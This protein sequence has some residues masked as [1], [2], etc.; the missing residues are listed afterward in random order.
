MKWVLVGHTGEL[1]EQTPNNEYL[2]TPGQRLFLEVRLSDWADEPL[3]VWQGVLDAAL[4]GQTC[5]GGG[6][7]GAAC[8]SDI[9]CFDG[10]TCTANIPVPLL[11]AAEP[12]S[13][14][15]D[16]RDA[17]GNATA[18]CNGGSG[19]CY[20][21]WV[22]TTRS[23][24]AIPSAISAVDTST[25]NYRFGQSQV[26]SPGVDDGTEAYG[27]TLA[28]DI[29]PDAIGTSYVI[30]FVDDGVSSFMRTPLGVDI[31][32]LA[33]IPATITVVCTSSAMCD[34][35][36][37]CTGQ[38]TCVAGAC[39]DGTFPCDAGIECDELN[40]ICLTECVSPDDCDD[41]ND[42]TQNLCVLSRCSYPPEAVGVACGDQS[43]TECDEPNTCDGAGTCLDNFVAADTACGDDTADMCD[44]PDICDGSGTCSMN[45]VEDGTFCESGN[46]CLGGG[47]CQAGTCVENLVSQPPV[48][49]RLGGGLN[50]QVT[51]QPSDASVGPVAL[52]V[53]SPD[54][55]C[56]DKY[57]DV[58][59]SLTDVPVEQLPIEWGTVLVTGPEISPDSEYH[60]VATCGGLETATGIG[61]SSIFGDLTPEVGDNVVDFHDISLSVSAFL[62]DSDLPVVVTDIVGPDADLCTPNHVTDFADISM[63]V[64]LFLGAHYSDYC[65]GPCP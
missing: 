25:A 4:F 5:T 12:C 55:P 54:W 27:G 58:D 53:T 2:V 8:F 18:H 59:G 62:G 14:S 29:S 6:N 45:F 48:V 30:R 13:T 35:G 65:D 63:E 42:C 22:D 60:V 56:V 49:S 47:S 10:G 24:I 57:I 31:E 16:C 41:G 3:G 38:E 9:D 21:G 11:P 33:F 61:H 64:N 20:A 46:P 15:Q 17:F 26:Q 7:P 51:P 32:P 34:D 1:V 28:I 52:R 44:N 19:Y 40:N 36:A 23:D 37:F 43:L 50:I 39:V